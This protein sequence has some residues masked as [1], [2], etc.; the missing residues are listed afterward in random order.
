MKEN[1]KLMRWIIKGI[2]CDHWLVN[3]RCRWPK[4]HETSNFITL[5]SKLQAHD[6]SAVLAWTVARLK[7]LQNVIDVIYK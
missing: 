3:N 6:G 4:G 1:I 2:D 5:S 7:S